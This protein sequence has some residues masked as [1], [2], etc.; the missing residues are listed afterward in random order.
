MPSPVRL[1]WLAAGLALVWFGTGT[2]SQASAAK[3]GSLS[4]EPATVAL[5][6][7]RAGQQLIATLKLPDGT[8]RDVTRVGQW[9]T[10]TGKVHVSP[11]GYASARANGKAIVTLEH[12]GLKATATITASGVGEIA[13]VSFRNEVIPV[14]N[15]AGCNQGACHGTPNGK[16]G[17][18]LSL[19]GYDPEFDYQVL[20]RE[21][22]GR[23]T[24]A[25]DPDRSLILQKA[26]TQVPHQGGQRFRA[27]SDEHKLLK[28]WI[29]EGLADDAAHEATLVK[30]EVL[31]DRRVILLGVGDNQ[32]QIVVLAQFSDG[33]R[34][35]VTRL[36]TYSTSNDDIATASATGLVLPSARGEVAVLCRYQHLIASA[37]LTFLKNVDGFVWPNP[38]E[39]NYIDKYIHA[40]LKEFQIPPSELS[41]DSD[42]LRRVYL[43]VLGVLPAADE[44][45]AFLAD[46]DADRR[47]KLIER[48]LARPEFADY[49]TLKWADLLRVNERYLDPP[50]LKE[51]HGWIHKHVAEDRPLDAFARELLEATGE[52]TKAPAVNFFRSMLGPE[53]AAETVAQLFL[54]VR[55]GCARCHNH[56]FEKWTQED[57]YGLAAV[58]AQVSYQ[59]PSRK[60][61][62]Y[63]LKINNKDPVLHPRTGKEVPPR[64][65]GAGDLPAAKDRRQPF[66]HWLTS[67][68]NSFFA[69]TM[70]N[71]IWFHLMGR[72][73]VEPVDDFRDSNPPVNEAL[74]DALAADFVQHDFRLKP[75]VRTILN[76]RTYQLSARPNRLN[77]HDELYFSRATVRLLPA[78]PM[79]DAL[80]AFTGVPDS[81]PDM[82]E[83][84][85]AVQLPGAK[86]EHPFLKAFN[87][88]ARTLPC[89]C[90][91]EHEA[92]LS[93]AMI[94][95]ASPIVQQK[96]SSD[97]GRIAKL[98]RSA[99]GNEEIIEELYLS[100]LS[101]RP[102]PRELQTIAAA[103]AAAHDRRE[104]LEDLGWSLVNSK[105]FQFRH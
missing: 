35:D 80:A 75:L 45:R 62:S 29:A 99:L 2:A 17:F 50:S 81:F 27:G 69:R 24:N 66:A 41:S 85:R 48:V 34:R 28:A 90:E 20:T 49:W 30:L 9:T 18:K 31:P 8:L 96:L 32:Q 82:P 70:V 65:L 7:S 53:Q 78:E 4:I 11:T 71:R 97:R 86:V 22:Y 36:C 38:P 40:R 39:N 54:G 3:S 59:V 33:S 77:K 43:D 89:E 67:A 13:P 5:Q 12:A 19:R 93:Q 10:D 37:R 15:R 60:I 84:T 51:F 52:S 47:S 74:L 58:F 100:A 61:K 98:A 88:P 101:R 104:F 14:L 95:I 6:G 87:R 73:L 46:K 23:R 42:F 63:V 102:T 25:L 55:L 68:G 21:A 1:C 72:G 26:L 57:Y 79:L 103:M 94:M 76:S 44:V 105:E 91:R 92:N 56:P 83:G 64:R 16:A